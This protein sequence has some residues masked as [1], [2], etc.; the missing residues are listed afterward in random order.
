MEAIKTFVRWIVRFLV[1]WAVDAISLLIAAA[2]VPGISFTLPAGQGLLVAAAAAA[3]TLGLVNLLVRPLILLLTLPLGFFVTFA[4]SF[5]VNALTLVITSRLLPTFQVE[6]LIAAFLGGL[7]VAVVNTILTGVMT[8]DDEDSFYQGVVERLARRQKLKGAAEPGRGIVMME[9]DGLSYHHMKHALDAGMM[10]TLKQMM[11]EEGYV[12]SRVDCGLPSQTSACQAGIMFGDNDDIP[13]FRW[14]DKERGKV[15]VS[16]KDATEINARYAKGNG[17]MR[18]GASVNNML[19]GDAEKSI[20]TLA[21]L[22][23]G[24]DEEKRY[25]ARDIALL[26][27]NPYFLMRTIVLM[28][29]DALLEI[30]QYLKAR[31]RNVQPR[32]DRLHHGYPLLRAACT[33]FMRDVAASLT[34]LNIIRGAPS[35]YVTWPGYDEVAHH[36]GPWSSDAFG[37]LKRYDP[38]IR[39]TRYYISHKAPRPYELLILSDHGQSFGATFKQ[40]YGCTLTEFIQEQLPEGT[41][42]SQ[43]IGGDTGLTTIGGL[44]GELENV[45]Q[46]GVSGRIGGAVIKQGRKAAQSAAE[47]EEAGTAPDSAAQV[48]AF[49]SG[50]LAQV[51]FDLYPRKITLSELR[52]AYPGMVDALVNHEA[53]GI[54]AGYADD[55]APVVLGKDGRRNLHTGEVTGADPLAPYGDVDLRAWQVRRVM[56]FPHAGDLMVNSSVFPDGTVAALEELIGNHGGMGGEQTDAFLFHPG[57]MVVPETR[58]SADLF[59]ILNARRGLPAAEPQVQP[60]G[61]AAEARAWAPGSLAAGVYRRPSRWLGRALRSLVLDRSAY[62]EVAGDPAMTGPAVLISVL[63]MVALAISNLSGWSWA[64][65]LGFAC[66]WL[67]ALAVMFGAARLLGG[68]GSYTA[69]LR[70]VG[71]GSVGYLLVLLALLPPLAPLARPLALVVGFFGTWLG[72]AEAN[73]LRGWRALLLPVAYVLLFVV[74]VFG[75]Y[76]LLAGAKL[77]LASLAQAL[78]LTP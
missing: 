39:R 42:A 60:G 64:S 37:A 30:T 58:N 7:I 62:G 13:A 41:T 27:V 31:A 5:V 9:V 26:A 52:S 33:V 38:V 46:Q 21:D 55:G 74:I 50:N 32:L 14:Y 11:D 77:S 17:L 72:A 71:F 12:L 28:F 16:S 54:V 8:V 70:G 56:D 35:I 69:T 10:P 43:Q 68:K 36:S 24:T 75:I 66:A 34:A 2:I 4:I 6:G 47:S 22:K 40:R 19:N 59:H 23:S 20:L 45:E 25:R 49:G 63:A 78:G 18:G 57:D 73:E 15:M 1:L 76:V 44:S 3:F 61:A 67:V 48:I 65:L 29:G 51:Y 53:I